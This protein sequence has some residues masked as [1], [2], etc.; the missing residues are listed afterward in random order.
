MESD[1]L[2]ILFPMSIDNASLNVSPSPLITLPAE[3]VLN[4][5]RDKFMRLLG[6]SATIKFNANE[7]DVISGIGIGVHNLGEGSTVRVRVYDG[8]NQTGNITHDSGEIVTDVVKPFGEWVPGVDP[9][10]ATWQLGSLLPQVF[11]HAFSQVIYKSLRIDISAPNNTEIDIGRIMA[12]FV[13]E[14]EW[15]YE[16]GSKWEWIED[17]D[18]NTVSNTYRSFNFV[19]NELQNQEN[20]RYEYEKMKAGK[21]G[22]FIVCSQ[23][24][25]TGLELLKNTAICKRVNNISRT[26]HRANANK[27]SDTFQEVF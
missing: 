11:F 22:D 5:R 17:G 12:G 26:R 16:W 9:V 24:S 23:P 7:L 8:F 10:L 21:Q 18:A 2:N 25:A 6:T 14:P 27:H 3:N 20:D 19:L 15:N 1:K 4:S 13:F